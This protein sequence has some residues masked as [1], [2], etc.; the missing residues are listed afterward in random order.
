MMNK[1][2]ALNIIEA[3]LQNRLK[4]VPERNSSQ[5]PTMEQVKVQTE[6]I[7][8]ALKRF[9]EWFHYRATRK[10]ELLLF[11][12]SRKGIED[13]IKLFPEIGGMIEIQGLKKMEPFDSVKDP[14]T[15][16]SKGWKYIEATLQQQGITYVDSTEP[17]HEWIFGNPVE[18]EVMTQNGAL[19]NI[20]R[21]M[22]MPES[23][24]EQ[25]TSKRLSLVQ[26]KDLMAQTTVN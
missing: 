17:E 25:K 19:D 6:V 7:I 11:D 5:P 24:E 18:I 12:V 16:Q 3:I 21:V 2:I 10:G 15:P 1:T 8:E 4:K 13:Y 9:P 26:A 14:N 23:T 20:H 22:Q